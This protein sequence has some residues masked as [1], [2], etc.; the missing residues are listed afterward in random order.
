MQ[1]NQIKQPKNPSKWIWQAASWR[2]SQPWGYVLSERSVSGGWPRLAAGGLV[3]EAEA[4]AALAQ[5][6]DRASW[7]LGKGQEFHS[8]IL[9]HRAALNKSRQMVRSAHFENWHDTTLPLKISWCFPLLQ[10]NARAIFLAC[11]GLFPE[12]RYRT[13]KAVQSKAFNFKHLTSGTRC[14]C[15]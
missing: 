1:E 3:M 13:G 9:L 6:Q 8:D 2:K 12:S 10:E 4:W 15:L 14:L 5:R 7:S 11:L